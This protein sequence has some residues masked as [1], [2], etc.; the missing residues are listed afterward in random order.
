M[1]TSRDIYS[2]IAGLWKKYT[3]LA[4]LGACLLLQ[5][6]SYSQVLQ[7]QR[8]EREQKSSNDYYHNVISLKEEGLILFRERDKYKGGNR[9]WELSL[10]DTALQEKKV[11]DIEVKERYKMIGYEVVSGG[12]Y[13]LYRTGETNKN[14]FELIFVKFNSDEITRSSIKPDLDFKVTHFSR[15][16]DS[17]AFGGYVN[18]EPTIFLYELPTGLIKVVPGFFQKDTELVDLRTNQNQT[19]N[20][21]LVDRGSKGERSLIFR[22][23]NSSGEMLL[24]DK[25]P[26]EERVTLQT[27][28]TST[29]EREELMVFGTWGEKNS[30]QSTGFFA[31]PIDPFGDQK[32]QRIDFGSLKH[33]VDYLNPKRAARIKEQAKDA[34]AAKEIPNFINYVMPFKVTEYKDG[35]LLLAEAYSPSSSINPYYSSP[36]Y[37][38]PYSYGPYGFNPY[39]PGNYYPGMSRLYR[40]YPYTTN[41]KSADEIKTNESV[42]VAFDANG[43][44]MWDQ[45]FKLEEVKLASVEQAS[46]FCIVRNKLSIVYKKESELKVKSIVLL[47]DESQEMTEKVKTND[48]VDEI[49]SEKDYEGGVR[50]WYNNTFYVWGYQ[51]IRNVTKEDRVRDVFYINKVQIH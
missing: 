46:D 1:N 38:N 7:L 10:L 20:S 32:I 24:E 28:I 15:A 41:S 35:Y 5:I 8:Y 18:N 9:L 44:V 4:W 23:F 29:L 45:S 34:A 12:I 27:G 47:T 25:V 42:V 3:V 11:V 14:D 49:R 22:T 19:F 13:L 48:P 43:N 30:K 31:L 36:Y 16:G 2:G 17:F 21:V 39:F 37:Y 26:I 40:P 6:D 51:T 33:Y 50:Q